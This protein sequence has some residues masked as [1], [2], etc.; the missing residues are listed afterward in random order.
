MHTRSKSLRIELNPDGAEAM[1]VQDLP[2]WD[3]SWPGAYCLERPI[4]VGRGDVL[5]LTCTWDNTRDA[6]AEDVRYI[7]W[8][9]GTDE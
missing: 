3:C 2:A 4:A 9:E 5:R 7:T 8:G 1:V 6:A